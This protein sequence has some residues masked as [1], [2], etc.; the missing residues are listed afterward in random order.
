MI[1][2]HSPVIIE[3][4]IT[5]QPENIEDRLHTIAAHRRVASKP[6]R[7]ETLDVLCQM[8][9]QGDPDGVSGD[10]FVAQAMPRREA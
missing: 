3:R 9:G 5:V 7:D 6:K 10:L 4:E 8:G 1:C 2:V